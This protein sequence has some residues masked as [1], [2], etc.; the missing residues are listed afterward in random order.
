MEACIEL[1]KGERVIWFAEIG[2]IGSGIS[3]VK[4]GG[5]FCAPLL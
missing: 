3:L 4:A 5:L 2:I 1:N